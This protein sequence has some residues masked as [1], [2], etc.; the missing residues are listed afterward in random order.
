MGKESGSFSIGIVRDTTSFVIERAK[1]RFPG[2]EINMQLLM[3]PDL[4]AL[5]SL[6]VLVGSFIGPFEMVLDAAV[7]LGE[8][9]FPLPP[10]SST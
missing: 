3:S 6:G 4:I 1:A 8:R 2:E 7:K 9:I 5:G 10:D